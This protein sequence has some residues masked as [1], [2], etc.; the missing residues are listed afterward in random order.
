MLPVVPRFAAP[1]EGGDG[2]AGPAR[3]DLGTMRNHELAGVFDRIADILEI[4]GEDRFRINSYRKVARSLSDLTEDVADIAARG[5]LVGIP[6]VGKSTVG[7]IEE[8]LKTG[9]M[10]AYEE[11]RAKVPPGLPELLK[12]GGLGPKTVAQFWSELQIAGLDDLKAALADGRIA[13]LK[14]FGEKKLENVRKAVAELEAM[15][16]S[17]AAS[18]V[19]LGLA[20]PVAE[21][22]AQRLRG[23]PG[24]L[25]AEPAGSLRRRKESVGD[26]DFVV[27]VKSAA[28][29]P[30]VTAAVTKFP[31]VAA[32][33]AHG[34]TKASVRLA[35]DGGTI[36]ADVRAV[37]EASFGAALQYFTGSKEHNVRVREIAVR[38]GMRLNEY[39]L[40]RGEEL[41][42]AAT[43]EQVYAALGMAWVPP[44]LREDRGEIDAA[45]AAASAPAGGRLPAL[46]EL[47]DIR[48]DLHMHT[49]ASD[50]RNTIADMAEAAKKAGY[51]YIAI[52]D[53]S[54]GLA[55]ARGLSPERLRQH[56]KDI[57]EAERA[58]G[59]I[60]ILAGSEVDIRADGTLD[61]DDDMLAELDW[62]IGSIHGAM[63]M[64]HA[65]M[66]ARLL[67]AVSNPRLHVL[68]H[69][70]ARYIGRRAP[71]DADWEAVIR[72]CR[73]RGVA[74]EVNASMERLDLSDVNC[75]AAVDAG[76]TLVISTDSHE[77][78]GLWQM[79]LGVGTARRG[80]ARK[81]DVLNTRDL[82]GLEAWLAER[83]KR[84]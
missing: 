15:K 43:E 83:R 69:P 17:G 16:A 71:V 22:V 37:P 70:T 82:K 20:W 46:V 61:Y 55:V 31:E 8:W 6:G 23:L 58:V 62:V 73:D 12:I 56:I 47:A 7:K 67:K 52:T 40:F 66:T 51:A 54:Q 5:A 28:D 18:R 27:A 35:V 60:R 45:S 24:V 41:V 42:A 14:G 50:G 65:D 9:K 84:G 48:G 64:P 1:V 59:G 10:A 68:G 80:W 44:E 11:A 26:L 36:Q 19:L 81:S 25:R 33:L 29:A 21:S 63:N 74:M 2:V 32:V 77:T 75:R 78:G 3:Y 76:V 49:T 79:P 72:A 34:D 53:H 39:G 38:K 13:G 57:R 4:T 30:A